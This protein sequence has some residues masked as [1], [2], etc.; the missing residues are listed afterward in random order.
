MSAVNTNPLRALAGIWRHRQLVI[1]LTRREVVGRYRGSVAGLAWS[2]FN[3]LLLLVAYTFVFGV[4]FRARWGGSAAS[5]SQAEF[6]LILFVGLI[7]HALMA[8]C[9]SRAPMLILNNANFVKKV[10]F[11]LEV[12]PVV[13]LCA[14]LFHA[15]ISLGVFLIASVLVWG[16]VPLTAIALPFVLA[17]F[18][19]GVL[20]ATWVLAS[21]GV[22]LRDIGQSVG[23]VVL[24]LMFLSPIFYP[25]SAVPESFQ[26]LIRANPLTYYVE[27]S[28]A[29][30]IWGRW[31]DALALLGQYAAAGLLAAAGLW[32]F[33]RT[34]AG[35]ADVI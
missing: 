25:L 24:L 2:F 6:A 14:A 9:V 1:E 22:Y 32:W 15:L 17:P 18:L 27:A 21:L 12:L 33:Q 5:E 28:R 20:G 7:Y 16:Q 30:L 26:P 23:I 8:E 29:V 31:P 11:P 19:I 13:T 10:V 34:R 3:P 35:F 4:V